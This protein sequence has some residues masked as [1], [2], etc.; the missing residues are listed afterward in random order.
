[1]EEE[2]AGAGG[3][4]SG[5]SNKCDDKLE[6]LQETPSSARSRLAP[7]RAV[8]CGAHHA[9]VAS[10]PAGPTQRAPFPLL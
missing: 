2:G 9:E 7:A 1:M 3:A 5:D 10:G 8:Q 6:S 4:G